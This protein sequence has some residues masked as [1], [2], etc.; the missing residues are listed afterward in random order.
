MKLQTAGRHVLP[1]PPQGGGMEIKMAEFDRVPVV[2]PS[3][4]PDEKLR[5]TVEGLI[6]AGF[7]DII[8][9]DDGSR[10][11]TKGNFPEEGENVTVLRH[12]VNR[13]KGAGLK[14]AFRYILENRPDA[15][16]CV[17]ADGDGQHRPED[18][19]ACVR[20][21][22]AHPE[23]IVLGARDFSLPSVP[24]RSRKGNRI[25]SRVFALLFGMTLSDT[26]TGLRAFPRKT[27]GVML[28][29]RG[30]R[31]E[32]ETNML[33]EMKR[34]S[35]GYRE[36]P[37]GTVYLDGN[38]TSHFRPVRDSVRIYGIIVAFALSSVLSMLLDQ[39]LFTVL[40]VLFGS[41]GLPFA[42]AVAG[43]AARVVSS[44]FNY[45]V[46]RRVVFASG[47]RSSVVRY[48]ILAVC[49]L[50]VSVAVGQTL[51]WIIPHSGRLIETVIKLA[52]DMVLFFFSFRIQNAWVF[53][54]AKDPEDA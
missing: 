41:L 42:F 13:G 48:Y 25:T 8:V 5:G 30:D 33:I 53:R 11:D 20:E 45:T 35:I 28:G 50:I 16:G 37:I 43:G 14:T 19:A 23:D 21:M 44:V 3:L 54:P 40:N 18:V 46:N 4:N 36:V 32:Y 47:D 17:S 1:V 12:E 26:Q 7:S 10:E 2:I 31:Y 15:L 24:E 9:I 29:V 51:V 34:R 22:I 6:A 39:T 52:V 27:L 49:Q 38:A